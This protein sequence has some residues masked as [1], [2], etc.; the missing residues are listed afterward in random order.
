MQDLRSAIQHGLYDPNYE[1][2]ACGVGMVLH[3]KGAKSHA[4]VENGLRVLENMTHRGAENADNKTGD[5]AGI[6]LQIPHE[7][8]LLQGIPVPEK[9]HYGTG[10]VFLPKGEAEM[11]SCMITLT[12]YID[13]E[14][15]KLLAVRDVPVNSEILGEMAKSN[16]PHIKQIFVLGEEGLSQD[17]LEHKLYLLR[18]KIEKEIFNSKIFSLET[19]RAFYIVSLST[20]RL[21]YKGM[22]SSEQLRHYYPDLLNPHLTSAIALVHSRFSTNTFPTWDLAH[23]FR[24]VAHNGEINT[25]KGNRLWMEARESILKSD[26]LG[27]INDL[28][29]IVQPFMSDSASFDNVLEFLVMSGK[30]LPH[31]M[32]MMVPESWNDQNPISDDL[33]AFYEYHSLFMEP[34]DG[35]ATLLFSDGRYAGGLLDRNGLRPARYLITH[36]D[37]M[38]VASEM[39]V[40]PF[41]P[42]E[43]KEK[44]RLRPGKILMVDTEK[45]TIQYD[46]ELKENLAKAY[47]YR[48]WLSKN[49]ISLDDISSGRAPKYS[50]DNYD[51]LLKVFGYYKEDIEKIMTPMAVEGKEPTASM[52][53]DAPVAVLS[54]KPQRLFTYFRQLFAQVTNP[55]IDPIREELVMSLAGYIG[56]LHKN[57]LEPMPEHTKMVGLSNPFLSNRELDLLVHLGYKG[58][59]AEIIPM[60]FD[61]KQGGAGLEKAIEQMC[62]NAEKAVDSGSNYIVLSDR[63]VNPDNAAIPSLLAVSAVHHYLIERRKRMQIDIVVESAEPREVMHFALLFGYGANA[64][65]PYLALAVIEDLVK[66]GDIHLDFHTAMK[67]YVK[68]INKGLLK[69][70]SKMGISTLKSY[71]GAQ[72]F[73][74]VG[75]STGV[76]D[77][78]FK[79]TT[80][81]IE[82]I[83]IN[84]IASDTIEAFYEAFESDFIDPS[85]VSQGIYAWRRNGEYHA[86]NPETIMNLQMATRLGSYKKFKEYTDSIDKKTEKIF[87]RDFLDFDPSKNPIDVSEVEPVSAITKRFVTGAM[88]FGSISREAHEA[89]AVAMNAIGGKSNTGEGGELPE[90]FATNA[91]SSIKQVAS[92]RFGVTTEYLVNADELQIKIAQG[93]KPGEGGQ[94][95]GFKV[96]KIIAKTRHSIPGISLISPPPHHDIY[97]IEDLAQLIFDLKNV[98][99]AAQISVKLVSESGVGT[100]AAGVAK[101]K[102]DRIVIS[103]CEGGTGASPASSIKH[104][105]LPLEIGLA[106]VQQTLVL[107]GLRG[108]VYLQTDGQLKTGHDI[109]VAAMLGAEEFGFATSALIVLGCIMMRKCHLNTCPVGVA[110][111]NE[112]LRKKFMGRSEYLINYF[113]FLAEEVREHLAALGVKSLDEVVGRADLL[114][115]MKSDANKKVEKLDLSRLMY[116][117]VEAKEN[118]IHR[119]KDQEHK[120]DDALDISLIT[121]S[122][123]AIDKAMPTVMTKTIKNTNR[124]VG[125]MLSGEIAKKYGNAGLPE[126]TI[127]FTFTGSAG[128]SFGAFLAHGVTFKLEGDA[129]DYVGKGL[130]GGKIIIVPPTT[131]TFKPEENIIAGNTL[132]YGAT[133]GE[134]YINGRVGERF[135]VRNSGAVAVV[136]GAGDH[137]CEYM[138][139]GRTVVLG[140]TGRNFAA[141][142]SGGVAY[143]YNI[144]EDF[145]YYCN[146]QM[147]EL[148]LIEDTYDSRE[149]RQ[150][151]TNHYNYTN[152]PLAKYILDNWNTEVE[153]FMKV[154]PIEYKKVLQDEKLEA[155]KK[156]IAQVEFDY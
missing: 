78:Y 21:I 115:Y 147:V 153:K 98:N 45:G 23:P 83:D 9:G 144:D 28:W 47:P 108:Q 151:I 102:A 8:I 17:E 3:M 121:T 6:M 31:A 100:I 118:A 63:G 148:T 96:D 24:M 26:L 10:L 86:W 39:G 105:G 27:N 139:G 91:R 94:L 46:A 87:L 136:E 30:S 56:S 67:N 75:I 55:P 104:A 29:P 11:E 59:K 106:E 138:T 41:E 89:M 72:I 110:T 22:L 73:E 79:G 19:K 92:G 81:K 80:S 133:S 14:G 99:P 68:S 34:W 137:C 77:K 127:Q 40:L 113:N 149:L 124:T 54:N 146:M 155:I 18:K 95:P 109:I 90:R 129:N 15:L 16:E 125:A 156:K 50:V 44:G 4:I 103:G 13:K 152:S 134:I 150:L 66:K 101:A 12:Q 74:A 120:L 20:K 61:P 126:D 52:G 142:M 57:I 38:V 97:S 37:V 42:S 135:C 51:K 60:L 116:F 131:S 1:H 145:D 35:P 119:I 48:E 82:G 107:N 140:K 123:M 70:M 122:R 114:K 111:Q 53:N 143:V 36:N 117:P 132:L 112:E 76:V 2:D 62:R 69:T 7:F 65:N 32:A 93:A 141:G 84:D 5:G 154:T 64:V 58:F 130:S 128:Q 85:L 33:K 71:I 49:R 25:I 43:I 88:S